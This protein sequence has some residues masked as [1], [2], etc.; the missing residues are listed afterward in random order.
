MYATVISKISTNSQY[1]SVD[2]QGKTLK[3]NFFSFI[4]E[5]L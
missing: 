4:Y 5:P 2:I 3:Y 1:N